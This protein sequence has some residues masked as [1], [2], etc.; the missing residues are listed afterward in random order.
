[1]TFAYFARPRGS[2]S[3]DQYVRDMR[4]DGREWLYRSKLPYEDRI[5]SEKSPSSHESFHSMID[6][7]RQPTQTEIQQ[8]KARIKQKPLDTPRDINES[9]YRAA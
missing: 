8:Q 6:P 7:L 1:M 3:T 2:T 4:A 5:F 9:A